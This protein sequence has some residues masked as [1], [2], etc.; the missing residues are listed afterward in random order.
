[1]RI[2]IVGNGGR[3]HALLWKLLRDAPDAAFFATRPTP[4][5]APM[6]EAVEIA[7]TDVEALADWAASHR[8]DCCPIVSPSVVDLHDGPGRDHDRDPPFGPPSDRHHLIGVT[9][10]GLD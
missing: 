10:F 5:M 2:L 4:G 1:M 3:E 6:C 7:P 9:A 8:I